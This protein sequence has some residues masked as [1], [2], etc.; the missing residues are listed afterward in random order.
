MNATEMRRQAKRRIDQLPRERLQVADDFLAYLVE[1]ESCE[2]TEEL[3]SIPGFEQA[4]E[5]ASKEAEE[6]KLTTL[7]SLR[8]TR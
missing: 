8:R 4:F 5:K 3:L 6:G 7:D 2:A 1:R